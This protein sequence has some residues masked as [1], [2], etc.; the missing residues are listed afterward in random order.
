MSD[1]ATRC[2][3]ISSLACL[4]SVFG[5]TEKR[6]SGNLNIG[7]LVHKLRGLASL[8]ETKQINYLRWSH[9]QY[10]TNNTKTL[11]W[12]IIFL[13]LHVFMPNIRVN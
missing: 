8:S 10:M 9:Y 4:W 6:F 11:D 7:F 13:I 1:D 2:L 12:N 3:I 5:C